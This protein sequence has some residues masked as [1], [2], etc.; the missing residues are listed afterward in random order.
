MN[1]CMNDI[2][3]VVGEAD[4]AQPW[5]YLRQSSRIGMWVG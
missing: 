2:G 3:V 4:L 1:K 5:S